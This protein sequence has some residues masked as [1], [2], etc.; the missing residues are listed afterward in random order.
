MRFGLDD[1]E[2]VL[3]AILKGEVQGRTVVKVNCFEPRHELVEAELFEALADGL[4]LGRAELHEPASL[5][6]QL[7]RFS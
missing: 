7:Q 3:T 6:A 5:A 1:L 2:D 4:E